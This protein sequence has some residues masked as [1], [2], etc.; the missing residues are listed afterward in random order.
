MGTQIS[1]GK[2]RGRRLYSISADIR[3]TSQ[4]LRLAIFSILTGL[5]ESSRVLDLYAGS[6]AFGLEALSRGA[7]HTDFVEVNARL[8]KNIDMNIKLLGYQD[9]ATVIKAK[10]EKSFDTL[11]KQYEDNFDGHDGG[12]DLVF[13]DPPYKKNPWEEILGNPV[14]DVLMKPSGVL[15]AEHSTGIALKENYNNLISRQNRQYGDSSIT[16][17]GLSAN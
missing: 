12:Y 9:R 7:V 8:C 17:F 13:L 14:W 16:I 1:G 3:P 15:I 5:T 6:G 10:V 11:L 4:K 2:D